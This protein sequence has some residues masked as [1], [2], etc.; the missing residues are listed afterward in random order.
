MQNIQGKWFAKAELIY[1]VHLC[2]PTKQSAL[3][4]EYGPRLPHCTPPGRSTEDDSVPSLGIVRFNV[5]SKGAK[6]ELLSVYCGPM[7]E[8]S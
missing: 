1:W 5:T 6:Q 2:G 3:G 7:G 8:I 4:A